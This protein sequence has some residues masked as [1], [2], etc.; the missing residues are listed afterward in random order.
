MEEEKQRSARVKGRGAKLQ[1]LKW[2][3]HYTHIARANTAASID[4]P[5]QQE[6]PTS[7]TLSPSLSLFSHTILPSSLLSLHSF[8][9]SP[10]FLPFFVIPRPF[11]HPNQLILPLGRGGGVSPCSFISILPFWL[12]PPYKRTF[13][14]FSRSLLLSPLI[15]PPYLCLPSITY[16]LFIFLRIFI[17]NALW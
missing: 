17:R 2:L 3:A 4:Q 8:S 10:P 16:S 13:L 11:S 9:R 15:P 5:P 12:S 7:S 14:A 6:H 1:G